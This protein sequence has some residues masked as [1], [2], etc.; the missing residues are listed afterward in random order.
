MGTESQEVLRSLLIQQLR[1]L[2]VGNRFQFILF[3]IHFSQLHMNAPEGRSC[4]RQQQSNL[5][6]KLPVA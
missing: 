3:A 5:V 6:F 2:I 1:D 4:I